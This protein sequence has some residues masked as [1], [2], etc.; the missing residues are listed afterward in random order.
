[1][2]GWHSG[3][4]PDQ[5][6]GRLQD[7]GRRADGDESITGLVLTGGGAR[8]A[9][10]V[11]VL[12]QILAIGREAGADGHNP[13]GIICGTSAGAINACALACRS[14]D[15][16]DA[17]SDLAEVWGG[18]R[19]DQV[20]RSNLAQMVTSGARWVSLV[21]LGWLFAQRRLRPR[22]LLDNQ[23]LAELLRRQVDFAPAD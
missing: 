9:Y 18:F 6:V 7:V 11:G 17:V 10:Q 1:M 21:S 19:V 20:Y 23:P 16:F 14:D 5:A 15:V 8:A 2:G 13:F 4:G 3:S 22:S 12:Q